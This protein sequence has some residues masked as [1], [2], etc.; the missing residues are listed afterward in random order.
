MVGAAW[1]MSQRKLEVVAAGKSPKREVVKKQ[2]QLLR[3]LLVTY[4]RERKLIAYEIHDGLAQQL[5]GALLMMQ[6][7]G[8]LRTSRPEEAEKAFQSG[9]ETLRR[10]SVETRRLISGLRPPQLDEGGVVGAIDCLIEEARGQPGGPS[11][12]FRA[13]VS[14][15]R[16]SPPLENAIFR[17]IQECL[18]N[19]CRYSQSDKILV[20]LGHHGQCV[21]L[22]VRD[23]GVGFSPRKTVYGHFGLHGIRERARLFGGRATIETGP[24]K[25]TR[26]TVDLPL[27]EQPKLPRLAHGTS[28]CCG[29]RTSDTI[30]EPARRKGRC[31]GE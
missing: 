18:T 29:I 30:R 3:R 20:K 25:G 23:W 7:Y 22:E 10:S 26:I 21:R 17:I 6:A 24:H 28:A 9:L 13:D 11:I 19:A 12:E 14:F 1:N 31:P 15:D 5:T 27:V 16:L 2:Q 4:E 8:E